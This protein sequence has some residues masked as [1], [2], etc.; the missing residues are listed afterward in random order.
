M[1]TRNPSSPMS[2]I[3]ISG[4]IIK[5]CLKKK[6]AGKMTNSDKIDRIV[7][8]RFLGLPIFAA[9]MFL[10]YY[11]SMVTVGPPPQIG[12]MTDCSATVGICLA[13]DLP[14]MKM[15]RENMATQR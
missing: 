6:S 3:F 10:V 12:Q 14:L 1:T 13:S 11:I 4:S 7:T 5:G 15:R 2:G 8:N 9:I